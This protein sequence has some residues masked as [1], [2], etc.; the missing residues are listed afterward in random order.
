[1]NKTKALSDGKCKKIAG[2][3]FF[4]VFNNTLLYFTAFTVYSSG[5]GSEVLLTEVHHRK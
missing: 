4:C 5:K 1:M 3:C 2:Q